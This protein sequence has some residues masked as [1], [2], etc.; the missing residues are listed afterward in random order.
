MYQN[1]VPQNKRF[2]VCRFAN[3][4]P[5]MVKLLS[6]KMYDTSLVQKYVSPPH[7]RGRWKDYSLHGTYLEKHLPRGQSQYKSVSQCYLLSAVSHKS[8]SIHEEEENGIVFI[9]GIGIVWPTRG[10]D[11]LGR[12]IRL[13]CLETVRKQ[14]RLVGKKILLQSQ[15]IFFCAVT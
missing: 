3:K 9:I 1:T 7:T 5:K 11:Q 4:D 2:S 10:I 13:V 6:L 8:Q 14:E 12:S 15:T